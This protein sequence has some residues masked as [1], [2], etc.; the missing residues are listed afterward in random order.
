VTASAN[1]LPTWIAGPWAGIFRVMAYVLVAVLAFLAGIFGGIS[2]YG[3]GLI[4][5]P[6]LLPITGPEP[7]VPIITCAAL[8][9]NASRAVAF[10]TSIDWNRARIVVLCALPSCLV[11]AY[12]YTSLNG[13]AASAV[14]GTTLVSLA[15]ARRLL[16]AR[17][18][19]LSLR[20][21]AIASVSY[22]LI[23]GSTSGSG[24]VLIT[25]MLATGIGGATVV[26]TDSVISIALGLSKLAIFQGTGSLDAQV[27]I[28]AALIGLCA[29]PGAFVAKR[30]LARIPFHVHDI[31]LD[32]MVVFG[33]GMMIAHAIWGG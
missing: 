30:L 25:L 19:T 24:V 23:V 22:G 6:F 21:L 15:V 28:M 1:F 14:I 20:G 11:G 26:A 8:A 16:A 29:T 7:I 31:T 4:L 32:A 10:R 27:W 3:S 9:I 2:G 13:P 12:F 18:W 5:P 33:G 17:E